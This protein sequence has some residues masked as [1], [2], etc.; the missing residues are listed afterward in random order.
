MSPAPLPP[1][2]ALTIF[3]LP[4]SPHP[5][6]GQKTLSLGLPLFSILFGER[7]DLAILITPLLIQHPLQLIV[8]AQQPRIAPFFFIQHPLQLIVRAQQP[9]IALFSYFDTRSN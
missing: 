6:L 2:S 4:L 5:A 1:A 7:D 8:R 9:C 3:H